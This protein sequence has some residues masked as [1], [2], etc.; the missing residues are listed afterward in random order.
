MCPSGR[1]LVV[2]SYVLLVGS[3]WYAVQCVSCRGLVVVS[4][5]PFWLGVGGRQLSA[6]LVGCWL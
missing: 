2:C 1:G 6:F 3:W 5:V 4:C